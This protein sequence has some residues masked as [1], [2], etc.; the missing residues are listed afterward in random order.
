LGNYGTAH[1]SMVYEPIRNT[2]FD[3]GFHSFDQYLK[4]PETL[5]YYDS[6]KPFSELYY[7][8]APS[9]GKVI[10]ALLSQKISEKLKL[11]IAFNYTFYPT[12]PSSYPNKFARQFSNNN[13][14]ALKARYTSKDKRYNAIANYTNSR[15]RVRENGGLNNY[16]DFLQYVYP[17]P[18]NYQTRLSSAENNFFESGVYL[19]HSYEPGAIPFLSHNRDSSD[20][21]ER[22]FSLGKLEHTLKYRRQKLMYLD[23]D[24]KSEYYS[25]IA[26]DTVPTFDSTFNESLINDRILLYG[27]EKYFDVLGEAWDELTIKYSR[28]II[29]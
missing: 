24:H 28:L 17:T 19:N 12:N 26:Y 20:T 7:K 16:E 6:E 23:G 21:R 22:K 3:F 25:F 11:G 1:Q 5:K 14:A 27:F 13:N 9:G 8:Q 18:S 2:D 15:V 10:D 4:R 29:K